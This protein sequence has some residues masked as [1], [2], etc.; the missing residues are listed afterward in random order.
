MSK[1]GVKQ[2]M[3]HAYSVWPPAHS[4]IAHA[5]ASGE[6]ITQYIT[7]LPLGPIHSIFKI[8]NLA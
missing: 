7:K 1:E 3:S 6:A 5:T 4:A 8:A 2:S